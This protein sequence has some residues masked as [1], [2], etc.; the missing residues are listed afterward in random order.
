MLPVPD[1]PVTSGLSELCSHSGFSTPM[2]GFF[3]RASS[4]LTSSFLTS[5][6][7]MSGELGNLDQATYLAY[8]R[9]GRTYPE[10]TQ[11]SLTSTAQPLALNAPLNISETRSIAFQ[12][13]SATESSTEV[14][15]SVV[16][17]SSDKIILMSSVVSFFQLIVFFFHYNYQFQC[18][19]NLADLSIQAHWSQIRCSQSGP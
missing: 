3:S 12:T 16:T 8:C 17:S 5:S 14:V 10:G 7:A 11:L 19:V 2:Q 13:M 18:S 15:L 4:L 6:S 1:D 9:T